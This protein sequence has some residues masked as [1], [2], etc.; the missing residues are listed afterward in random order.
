MTE[1]R[2]L[3]ICS[4]FA[5]HAQVKLETTMSGL[6]ITVSDKISGAWLGAMYVNTGDFTTETPE[7]DKPRLSVAIQEA[8]HRGHGFNAEAR[9]MIHASDGWG[10]LL[11]TLNGFTEGRLIA[12]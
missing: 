11:R 10:S 4:V 9:R 6:R 1:Y 5:G 12:S 7:A 3:S 8:I 2:V